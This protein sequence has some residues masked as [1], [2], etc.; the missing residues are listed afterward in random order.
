MSKKK[1]DKTGN[2]GKRVAPGHSVESPSSGNGSRRERFALLF[3]T[4]VALVLRLVWLGRASLWQDEM[5]FVSILA[6]PDAGP[7]EAFSRYWTHLI[8]MGQMPLAGAVQNIYIAL[9][10][11]IG[12]TDVIN[13]P[14]IMRFPMAVIGALAVPGIYGAARR[15]LHPGAAWVAAVFMA[16]FFFPVYYSREAY[17]YA[18]VL[19]FAAWGWY[20]WLRLY[21]GGGRRY[22]LLTVVCFAGMALSHLGAVVAVA[23][24]AAAAGALWLAGLFMKAEPGVRR[25]RFVSALASGCAFLLVSPYLI[26]FMLNN[27]AHIGA[28]GE[29]ALV[30]ILN[31]ALNKMF[32][33]EYPPF[34]VLAWVL[35]LTG[36]TGLLVESRSASDTRG[37]LI[38]GSAVVSLVL[39]AIATMNTQYLSA[40][41]FS[42]LIVVFYLII[43]QGIWYGG[44]L[45]VRMFAR[46]I[47]LNR[48]AAV[49]VLAG[50]CVGPHILVYLPMY[51]SL[52]HK[53][54]N[55]AGVAAWLNEHVEPGTPYLVESAFQYRFIGGYHPVPGLVPIAPYVHKSGERE[56][57]QKRQM[58]FIRR[59]PETVFVAL[60]HTGWDT[61]GELWTWPP[62]HFRNH[63]IIDNEPL[64]RLIELGIHPSEPYKDLSDTSYRMDIY[65]NTR[66]DLRRKALETGYDVLFSFDGWH[67]QQQAVSPRETLYYRAMPG[68]ESV[69]QIENPHPHPVSGRL[70]LMAAWMG[71]ADRQADVHVVMD[72]V[73]Q[74]SGT[75]PAG[76]LIET[77]I[78][79]DDL[80]PG[81]TDVR[82]RLPDHRRHVQGIVLWDIQ[83]IPEGRAEYPQ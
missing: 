46:F 60:G 51:W 15:A 6:A 41:Y 44:G 65:Y 3:L 21:T 36:L 45:L 78:P 27:E 82:L 71:A 22:F 32:L 40:R 62:S 34:A 25:A 61:P 69:F 77:V 75:H 68:A 50:L 12:F 80:S 1:Q 10:E 7:V 56:P 28:G 5:I 66:E 81:V 59:F 8:S 52:E 53:D 26:H 24:W 31:D 30:W 37:I 35:F 2:K 23:G 63:V 4:A 38:G 67:I 83:W 74:Y 48:V 54:E 42:P 72:G 33:G 39:L 9:L 16:V 73:V 11:E 55:Y 49:S 29:Y 43:A 18:Y 13:R 58:D 79:L 70:A 14:G 47:T 19:F 17:C 64:R 76:R 57:L 20:A